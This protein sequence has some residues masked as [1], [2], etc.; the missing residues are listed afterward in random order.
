MKP[1]GPPPRK[2]HN[3]RVSELGTRGERVFLMK[4]QDKTYLYEKVATLIASTKKRNKNFRLLLEEERLSPQ[5]V[6]LCMEDLLR[7]YKQMKPI[8]VN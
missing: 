4:V 2:G 3:P 5:R 7:I 6:L 1:A 8:E